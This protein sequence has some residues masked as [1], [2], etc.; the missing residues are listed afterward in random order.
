MENTSAV[1]LVRRV[2]LQILAAKSVDG[3]KKII[4]GDS[5]LARKKIDRTVYPELKLTLSQADIDD[6]KTSGAITEAGHLD[7]NLSE[8]PLTALE[9]LLYSMAWKNGDLRKLGHIIDGIGAA[10]SGTT[11]GAGTGQVF[12]QFG[13]HLADRAEPI[14]DQ[15]V[16]RAF[17]LF[18]RCDETEP[19]ISAIRRKSDW[20]RDIALI[21]KYKDWLS[22]A[23]LRKELRA[24]SGH[25]TNIDMVLFAAGR[26][27]KTGKA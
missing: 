5:V 10:G 27:I 25:V 14:I 17:E 7:L 12:H 4:E 15:H 1:E 19:A 13:R 3:L 6:L 20:N 26:A 21:A 9:K 22:N 23:P 8:R 16:L 2:F 24:C 18:D 11:R